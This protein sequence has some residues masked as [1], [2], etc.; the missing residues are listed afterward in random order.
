MLLIILHV[1]HSGGHAV[2]IVGV[3]VALSVVGMHDSSESSVQSHMGFGI[4]GENQEVGSTW[5]PA[6]LLLIQT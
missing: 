5:T 1:Y 2:H 4:G 6:D 3:Q